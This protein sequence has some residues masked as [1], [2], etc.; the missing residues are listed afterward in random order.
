[1]KNNMIWLSAM[2]GLV[3]ADALGVP[4]EFSTRDDLKQNPVQGMQAYGTHGQPAGTWSDDSSMTLATLD[5]IHSCNGIDYKDIMDRFSG[6]MMYGD[7]TPFQY[8]FD[9]GI[10]TSR[11]IINYGR[12]IGATECGGNT[13]QDNGNGSLM[14]ILPIC[15]YLFERQKTICTSENEAIYVIHNVSALTHAHIR[16]QIGCGLYFFLVKAIIENSGSMIECLQMGMDKGF[17]Y[18]RQDF[19]NYPD[20]EY[21]NR[22][23]DLGEFKITNETNIRSSGY[24]VH[25]LEAAIWCLLNSASY[26]DAVLKAV[27]LGEDTDTVGAVTGGLAGLYY[28]YDNIPKVWINTIQKKDWVEEIITGKLVD[29]FNKDE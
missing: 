10:S 28:G 12:G 14:R 20:L 3:V 6:W 8:N 24:I 15:L 13:E 22:L 2:M 4:V 17:S 25:T 1:M 19:K 29:L 26:E 9:I 23:I 5:S 16:S 11:A 21:Y 27:N 7:Y 18:Y